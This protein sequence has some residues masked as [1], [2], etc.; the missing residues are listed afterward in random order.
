[1]DLLSA[2]A[3]RAKRE[4]ED[5]RQV[6]P[7]KRARLIPFLDNEAEK[8]ELLNPFL[9][10][11]KDLRPL[12]VNLRAVIENGIDIDSPPD[13]PTWSEPKPP[14]HK[15]GLETGLL[16]G[17]AEYII[18][19]STGRPLLPGQY[20]TRPAFN[21]EEKLLLKVKEILMQFLESLVAVTI[22]FEAD[23]RSWHSEVELVLQMQEKGI[24]SL[25]N[26][27]LERTRK[28]LREGKPPR[29]QTGGYSAWFD[30]HIRPI[31]YNDSLLVQQI[32]ASD[33]EETGAGYR[34]IE[35]TND[36]IAAPAAVRKRLA[37]LHQM[38][39][40][41]EKLLIKFDNEDTTNIVPGTRY[42]ETRH[43]GK[44]GMFKRPTC[45]AIYQLASLDSIQTRDF[46]DLPSGNHGLIPELV[47]HTEENLRKFPGAY[48][49][50]LSTEFS[51]PVL[52]TITHRPYG[53]RSPV[54]LPHH[55]LNINAA[56]KVA[57][58]IAG[59]GPLA[60]YIHTTLPNTHPQYTTIA[61]TRTPKSSSSE[62]ANE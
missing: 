8:V 54:H 16:R 5:E 34:I 30:E 48:P 2:P 44:K 29:P 18:C 58:A 35:R 7:R 46:K 27:D 38:R 26:R 24:V 43:V 36:I 57:I 51:M 49:P 31:F 3:P 10:M 59:T 52:H 53:S 6:A 61:L 60:H 42:P 15:H 17:Y 56:M 45:H 13:V 25:A 37:E 9:L 39:E 14:K 22:K 50:I 12:P 21:T 19:D 55:H 47:E 23:T 20:L 33:S 11:P 41:P 40:E 4:L 1:M 28:W 62:W 32:R